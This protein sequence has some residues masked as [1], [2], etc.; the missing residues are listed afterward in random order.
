MKESTEVLV[1]GAGAAGMA[2]ARKLRQSG[3]KFLVIEGRDRIGGRIYS[4]PNGV[5]LG[6]EFVH[7]KPR[8]LL[9]LLRQ[10]K[11][12]VVGA[13]DSHWRA[14]SGAVEKIPDFWG[15][16]NDI[17][18]RTKKHRLRDRPFSHFIQELD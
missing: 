12:S 13:K 1:V 10:A 17:L 5:E 11:L 8:R 9:Q 16:L 2:A 15:R 18:S 4:L 14:E 7:G 3:I 6:A